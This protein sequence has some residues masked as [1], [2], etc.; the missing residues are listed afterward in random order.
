MF[1]LYV[2]NGEMEFGFT[3]PRELAIHDAGFRFG[4]FTGIVQ[5]Q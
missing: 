3:L 4:A 1:H 2:Q 5:F